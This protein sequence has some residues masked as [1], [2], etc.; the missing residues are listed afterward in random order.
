MSLTFRQKVLLTEFIDFFNEEQKPIS[1]IAVAKRLGISNSTA[2][3][4][5]R[6]FEQS[7]SVIAVYEPSDDES[8]RGRARVLFMPGKPP[9][10]TL[11]ELG[12]VDSSEINWNEIK[13]RLLANLENGTEVYP[14]VQEEMQFFLNKVANRSDESKEQS[15][16]ETIDQQLEELESF[17]VSS[18]ISARKH[19]ARRTINDLLSTLTPKLTP[20]LRC[21][22][23][24]ASLS[25]PSAL[26]I[27]TDV[28]NENELLRIVEET[29]VTKEG[30][31]LLVGMMLGVFLNHKGVLIN[32][33]D[34]RRYVQ[35]FGQSLQE[36]NPDE[37]VTIHKFVF[38]LYTK[39]FQ[40]R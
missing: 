11:H 13:N 35:L 31:N 34:Y 15:H 27:D 2:Y 9:L 10:D 4:M 16:E 6:K 20:L 29:P 5:L 19:K 3:E 33:N 26:A 40:A 14:G 28:S 23:I 7:G 30:I 25:I 8:K 32:K 1:Y 24:I 21:A 22:Q 12:K 36:L 37:I 39:L 17:T 38:S 18:Y